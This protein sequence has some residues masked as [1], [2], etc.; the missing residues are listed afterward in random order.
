MTANHRFGSFYAV[1][2]AMLILVTACQTVPVS[3]SGGRRALTNPTPAQ[4]ASRRP[5]QHHEGPPRLKAQWFPATQVPQV[6]GRHRATGAR[7]VALTFDDGPGPY[8]LQVLRVLRREHVS[9]TFFE[10]GRQV[11]ADPLVTRQLAAARM[12]VQ[13]HT[14]DHANLNR[15]PDKAI[16]TEVQRTNAAVAAA[17][18]VTPRCLRPPYGAIDS[19]VEQRLARDHMTPVTWNVDTVDWQR[20]GTARITAAA[21]RAARPG[22]IILMHDGGGNRAQTVTALPRIITGLRALGFAFTALCR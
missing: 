9:A 10:I 2:A 15:L 20:P 7:V 11:A 12:S 1:L 13:S 3:G 17:T 21:V 6:P 5:A 16:D 8:T 18:G 22:A 4:P 19:R 14:W